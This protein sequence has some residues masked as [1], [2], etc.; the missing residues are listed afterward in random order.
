M[1][2]TCGPAL[3]P[4]K[5]TWVVPVKLAP[6]SVT[7]LAAEP[8]EGKKDERREATVKVLEPVT[9]P[10]AVVTLMTP[11]VALAGTSAVIWVLESSV[12]MVI[13]PL[14]LTDVAPKKPLPVKMTLWPGA[15]IEGVNAVSF[16][17]TPKFEL[18]VALCPS[19]LMTLILPVVALAGTIAANWVAEIRVGLGEGTPLK[20][21]IVALE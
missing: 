4:L 12:E 6:A 2:P 3:I 5:K 16:G 11:V 19:A 1:S 9:L 18:L 14:N 17:F 21:M 15:P 8:L 7:M 10:P 20:L 13:V